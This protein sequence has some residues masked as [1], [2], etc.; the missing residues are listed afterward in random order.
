MGIRYTDHALTS[1]TCSARS[2]S[3]VRL[4]TKATEFSFFSF[5][6]IMVVSEPVGGIRKSEETDP[7][8]SGPKEPAST[9]GG[10]GEKAKD[11]L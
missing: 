10:L 7:G 3:I 4:R 9:I 5:R 2:A 11:R 6:E 1:P 8:S